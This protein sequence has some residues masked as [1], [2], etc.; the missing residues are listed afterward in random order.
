M[1]ML[2]ENFHHWLVGLFTYERWENTL[3]VV[4]D[5]DGSEEPGLQPYPDGGET[6]QTAT[7]QIAKY[8]YL[9]NFCLLLERE[10]LKLDPQARIF[11]SQ[12]LWIRNT[13]CYLWSIMYCTRAVVPLVFSSFFFQSK[14]ALVRLIEDSLLWLVL[15]LWLLPGW[16]KYRYKRTQFFFIVA[17][18]W[19]RPFWSGA[20]I[21]MSLCYSPFPPFL[22]HFLFLV[23]FFS[24]PSSPHLPHSF[25]FSFPFLSA[26]DCLFYPLLLPYTFTLLPS[27]KYWKRYWRYR[28]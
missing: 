26:S 1:L 24:F 16:E 4:T 23:H 18:S 3:F 2:M 6:T 22:S 9:Y 10:E 19:N 27:H 17:Q 13:V 12:L 8:R 21:K 20:E 5:W 15:C 28:N 11:G 14:S 25:A 7:G